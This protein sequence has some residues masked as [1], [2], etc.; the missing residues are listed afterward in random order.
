MFVRNLAIADILYII[1]QVIPDITARM[2]HHT[3]ILGTP[4]CFIC[5]HFVYMTGIANMAFIFTIS[6]YRLLTCIFPITFNLLISKRKANLFAAAVWVYSVIPSIVYLAFSFKGKE[7]V[8][9]DAV[10]WDAESLDCT[11]EFTEQ[12]LVDMIIGPITIVLPF[13][14]IIVFNVALLVLA[15][16]SAQKLGRSGNQAFLTI[17][18][19]SSL[20]IISWLP[21]IVRK[22][23]GAIL[24]ESDLSWLK[25]IDIILYQF[26][27]FGNPVIYTMVNGRFRSW[28]KTSLFKCFSPKKTFTSYHSQHEASVLTTTQSVLK[29]VRQLSRVNSSSSLVT[30]KVD[31]KRPALPGLSEKT[32]GPGS[33][34][35][36]QGGITS[37][38]EISNPA[39]P[40]DNN[41]HTINN[42]DTL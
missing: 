30:V 22:V 31:C 4:A 10:I 6:L 5:A 23:V 9:W 33:L 42:T 11:L 36:E 35:S 12:G 16:K 28:I 25:K 24:E 7:T 1:L 19:V 18:A 14:G 20:F 21:Y 38:T 13:I 15:Y 3:W 41:N 26:S 29:F 32:E 17:S 2:S 8:I 37:Q 34:V 27:T 39:P 40:V